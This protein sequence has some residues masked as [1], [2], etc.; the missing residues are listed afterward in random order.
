MCGSPSPYWSLATV[1]VELRNPAA[2]EAPSFQRYLHGDRDQVTHLA[3]A[4]EVTSSPVRPE[5]TVPAPGRAARAY[6]AW[7]QLGKLMR[8]GPGDHG[9]V[10]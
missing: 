6:P 10:S 9:G 2:Q 5:V 7:A 8:S 4:V 3:A 1:D